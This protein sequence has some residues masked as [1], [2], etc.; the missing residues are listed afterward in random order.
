MAYVTGKGA[1]IKCT[2]SS[3]LTTI[4]QVTSITAPSMEMGSVE[5]T[6]LTSTARTF[7]PTIFDGAEVQFTV[8][9]N[10]QDAALTQDDVFTQ[11]KAGTVDAWQIVYTWDD[12]GTTY[13]TEVDF[14]AFVTAFPI[15]EVT[16]DNIATASITLKVTGDVTFTTA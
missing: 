4:G 1:L 14:S 13:T 6:H 5:T 12:G 3:T 2:V 10:D 8:E 9:W 16:V 7:L 15:D 11:F